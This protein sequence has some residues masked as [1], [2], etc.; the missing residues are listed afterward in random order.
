[1]SEGCQIGS[2]QARRQE[3]P[4]HGFLSHSLVGV[5]D[6]DSAPRCVELTPAKRCATQELT[7]RDADPMLQH[8]SC[9]CLH[10]PQAVAITGQGTKCASYGPGLGN[11]TFHRGM[12]DLRH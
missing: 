11:F 6:D 3:P 2:P 5:M 9:S 7:P 8:P 4:A 12:T 1:M 10:A